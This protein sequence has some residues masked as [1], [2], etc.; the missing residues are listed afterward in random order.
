MAGMQVVDGRRSPL[1]IAVGGL[2]GSRRGRAFQGRSSGVV[3][4]VASDVAE[5]LISLPPWKTV[6]NSGLNFLIPNLASGIM[7]MV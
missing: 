6:R 1:A 2:T 7:G 5:L 3:R 4:I